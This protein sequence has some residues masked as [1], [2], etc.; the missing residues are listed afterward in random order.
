M[1]SPKKTKPQAPAA[2]ATA[3][4][5][6]QSDSLGYALRRAQIR[7]YDLFFEKLGE[8]D[9]SPA[10]LTAL[11][12]AVHGRWHQ[13]GGAGQA[14]QHRRPER[15]RWWTRWSSPVLSAAKPSRVTAAAT[16]CTSPDLGRERLEA[17][18][19]AHDA[20]EAELAK[21]AQP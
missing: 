12:P 8:L 19:R 6:L 2:A 9:L 15:A 5:D 18:H 4:F 16:R 11:S 17:A 7:A 21:A 14:A 3:H 10:R 13:P 1:P 20:Y